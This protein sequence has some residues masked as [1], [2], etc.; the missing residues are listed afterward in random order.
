M[1]KFLLAKEKTQVQFSLPKEL[2]YW[3][4]YAAIESGKISSILEYS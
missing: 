3:K 1:V 4:K 2:K